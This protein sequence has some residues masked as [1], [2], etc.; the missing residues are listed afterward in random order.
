MCDTC[1]FCLI[2]VRVQIMKLSRYD[3]F[4]SLILF[5]HSWNQIFPSTLSSQIPLVHVPPLMSETKFHTHTEPQDM[6]QLE[7]VSI[8]QTADEKESVLN[9]M[10]KSII[11]M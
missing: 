11:R 1:F 9:C 2:I 6:L 4:S 5:H 8:F 3:I 10:L 7:C